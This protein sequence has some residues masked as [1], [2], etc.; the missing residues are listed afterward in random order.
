MND[1]N[2][3]VR[4]LQ[5]ALRRLAKVN[6]DIS[7]VVV[8][9]QFGPQTTKSVTDFQ[10]LYGLPPTGEVDEATFLRITEEYD[11]LLKT[12]TEGK[13]LDVFP[14]PYFT[15]ELNDANEI[16]YIIQSIVIGLAGRFANINLDGVTG[17]YDSQTADAVR[18]IQLLSGLEPTGIVD[19][20]TWDAMAALYEANVSKSR[21]TPF[22]ADSDFIIRRDKILYAPYNND[23]YRI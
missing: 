6:S 12:Y 20:Q 11:K 22:D 8:D 14:S 9:G 13:T 21:I 3:P 15:V 17:V 23:D 7:D 5:R 10:R 16:V 4:N 19:K 1:S 18:E 2:K